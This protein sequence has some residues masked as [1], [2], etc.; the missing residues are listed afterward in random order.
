MGTPQF[1]VWYGEREASADELSRIEQIEVTQEVDRF[2]EARVTSA[3]CL[4]ASGQWQ[5]RPD[6]IGAAFTR[7]RVELD[8]G[9]GRFVPLI[10]G[11]ISNLESTLDSQPGRSTVTF[12]VRDDSV[13]LNR[14]E[15]NEVF[16]DLKDSDI[17]DQVLRSIEQIAETR[18]DAT[19]A[20]NAVTSRRGT[21]L[22]FLTQLA[23][24]NERRIFV[25]PG[26]EPG[27]SIGCFLADPTEPNDEYPAL[28]LVGDKRNLADATIEEE[29]ESP[30]V[31]SARTLRL[32]DGSLASFETSATAL[33]ISGDMPAVADDQAALRQL[34]PEDSL[35]EDPAP[36]A[37]GRARSAGL[38]YR[39]SS[40]VVPG[41]YAAALVP[42]QRVRIECGSTPYSGSYLVTKVVH[43]I[44]PSQYTQEFEAQGDAATAI[45]AAPAAQAA[46]A[47]GVF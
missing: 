13:F 20:T 16:R 28:V 26:E 19:D 43:R 21:R 11:A 2:W 42:Y 24:A 1:R 34:A 18:I 27:R 14:E 5:H 41:C 36:A 47:V 33:G 23:R 4:D 44:T 9:N 6:E 15:A 37:T 3:M 35:R 22:A 7:M 32:S 39:L 10:D 8:P 40:R 46:S 25:L 38:A 45:A 12:A 30:E 17:A 29:S 31:T